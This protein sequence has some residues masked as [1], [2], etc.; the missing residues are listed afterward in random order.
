MCVAYLGIVR[1]GG[2]DLIV[3]RVPTSPMSVQALD[4]K[5]NL[6]TNLCRVP[7]LHDRE[8]EAA[9]LALFPFRLEVSQRMPHLHRLPN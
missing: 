2:N 3:K 5:D 1:G 9:I 6:L 4:C 8:T 7:R